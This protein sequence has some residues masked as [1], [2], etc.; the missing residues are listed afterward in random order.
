MLTKKKI[1]QQLPDTKEAKIIQYLFHNNG[2][3][4]IDN[5]LSNVKGL[6]KRSLLNV[7]VRKSAYLEYKREYDFIKLHR[8]G[9]DIYKT[10]GVNPNI[11]DTDSIAKFVCSVFYFTG[12]DTSYQDMCALVKQ[13]CAMKGVSSGGFCENKQKHYDYYRKIVRKFLIAQGKIESNSI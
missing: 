10:L 9:K 12:I 4:T 11:W 2:A 6:T 7:H 5:I 13:W 3:D 8:K 1:Q